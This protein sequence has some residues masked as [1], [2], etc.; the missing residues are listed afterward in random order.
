MTDQAE[1]TEQTAVAPDPNSKTW[2]Q[3]PFVPFDGGVFLY[4]LDHW[5]LGEMAQAW[6]YTGWRDEALSWKKT[7]YIHGHLNPSP[8]SRITGPDALTFLQAVCVNSFQKFAIG[9]SRHA[10]MTDEKGRVA[11]HGML[12]RTAEQEF[13]AYWLSPFLNFR[14][15]QHP[16]L[17]FTVDDLTGQVFL[18][19][20]GGPKSLEILEDATGENLHDV[21]FLRH[22]DTTVAGEQVRILRIGMAGTL[23]YELH[24]PVQVAQKVYQAVFDAGQEH[25]IRK[26]GVH[27]YMC[28]HTESGFPQA[29]YHMPLPWGE[30]NP[31]F[32][33]FMQMIGFNATDAIT[34]HGSVGDDLDRRFRSPYELGW[35]HMVNFNHDFPGKEALEKEAAADASRMVTLVWNGDDVADVIASQFRPG[36]TYSPME[37]PNDIMYEPGSPKAPQTLYADKVLVDGKD[38]GTSSGRAYTE[39]SKEVLS[40]ATI[41]TEHAAEGTEVVVL[42]GEPGDP[43]KEIRATV[44]RFPYLIDPV[45]NES[46]DV[47]TIPSKYPARA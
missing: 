44:A 11:A 15:M 41:A 43:Q 9:A 16:E 34:L 37:I 35:G 21:A 36:D 6:E 42:W 39:W 7:A 24:G 22:R 30:E 29:F 5:E 31:D 27:A 3:S 19:Q 18:F 40:L 2:P 20:I 45:R 17:D 38:V 33:A 28:N 4:S 12:V 26:L 8:T 10:V 47:S 25:G 14:Q 1:A 46:F 32:Y 23:A 13:Y